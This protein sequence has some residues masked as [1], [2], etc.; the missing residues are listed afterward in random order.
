MESTYKLLD[1]G[2]F[3]KQ[4]DGLPYDGLV[5]LALRIDG[6]APERKPDNSQTGDEEVAD[7]L[8]RPLEYFKHY[9]WHN[10]KSSN[11]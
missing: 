8:H 4:F 10:Y 9:Y 11:N 3:S 1:L 5:E 6:V 2:L 7:R